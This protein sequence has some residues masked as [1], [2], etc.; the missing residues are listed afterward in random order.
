MLKKNIY[1]FFFISTFVLNSQNKNFVS[2]WNISSGAFEL[3]LKDYT[4]ITIDWGDGTS[5]THTNAIFP[6]HTY[7]SSNIFTITIA[8][9]DVKKDIGSMYINGN[10]S[11]KAMLQDVSNWGEGIWNSFSSAFEGAKNLTISATDEPDL[12]ATYSM[13]KAFRNCFSL[14]GTTLNDWDMSTI[15]TMELMF[16]GNYYSENFV[17]ELITV[18]ESSNDHM[19]FNADISGWNTAAVTNMHGMFDQCRDFNVATTQDLSKWNTAAVK[20]MRD[21]FRNAEKFNGDI[22]TWNTTNV[23]LMSGVLN[24]AISFNGD[25]SKW[26]TANVTNMMFLFTNAV[27]FNSDISNWNTAKVTNMNRMFSNAQEF[28]Q[29]INT[30]GD[31]WNTKNVTTMGSMFQG[32]LKFNSDI[33]N[34]N[35]ANVTNMSS[36]FA[37]AQQFNQDINTNGDRWNTKNVTTMKQVFQFALK[38]NGDISNWNTAKVTTMEGLFE[39]AEKF[40]GNISNW[41]TKSVTNMKHMFK[42]ALKFNGT[43]A[44]WNTAK[45]TDMRS[46][47][48]YAQEFNQNISTR[49]DFWNT[50]AVTDMQF[51][52]FNARSFN[53]DITNWDTSSVSNMER[54]FSR[55]TS[56]NQNIKTDG[57]CWN[58]SAVTN[59]KATFEYA[60]AF[61]ADIATWD[62]SNVTNMYLI[63]SGADAL[64]DKKTAIFNTWK[65]ENTKK[66]QETA[67]NN[68]SFVKKDL[69]FRKYFIHILGLIILILIILSSK[70]YLSLHKKNRA[71]ISKSFIL[72]NTWSIAPISTNLS[73]VEKKIAKLYPEDKVIEIIHVFEKHIFEYEIFTKQGVN[74]KEFSN[75]T[76][77]PLRHCF[78]LFKVYVKYPF[79]KFKNFSRIEFSLKQIENNFLNKGTFESLSQEVGFESYSSFYNYFKEYTSFTP[80]DY[81]ISINC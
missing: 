16:S 36:M 63:F 30:N 69:F 48:A 71:A 49:E 66:S 23:T 64:K 28:N 1:I 5:T 55:A 59:M 20:D 4:N 67:L 18:S 32:A 76:G 19:I 80:S 57:D 15:T 52:F 8:V 46:M 60:S 65:I 2:T 29:N 26:N 77:I 50:S 39:N 10:H 35:T 42:G 27:K 68:S 24:G 6:T 78:Y 34:W 74:I 38:F 73:E 14:I 33:S 9:N 81:L 61:D 13:K 31:R 62:T 47:F 21:I 56:F 75:I 25:I 11:S 3:P 54:M 58:T 37:D 12:S 41:D 43:I 72:K 53:Q 51:M 70:R 7:T 22:S 40:N 17:N 45:V 44:N 79:N